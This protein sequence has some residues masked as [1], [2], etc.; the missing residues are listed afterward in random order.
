MSHYDTLKTRLN[1]L[2]R[3]NLIVTLIPTI[4]LIIIGTKWA[5]GSY[6]FFLIYLLGLIALLTLPF[7][8]QF[9]IKHI[10]PKYR[11]LLDE[12]H[13][14]QSQVS[15]L[16]R[17]VDEIYDKYRLRNKGE[18]FKRA[19]DLGGKHIKDCEER[20][21]VGMNREKKEIFV[22]CFIKAGKVVRV[23]ASIGSVFRCSASDDPRRW[24]EHIERLDCDEIRQYHNH[25]I[26]NNRTFPS[27]VDHKTSL[28]LRQILGHHSN[29][30]RSFIIY[31]NEIR[32][33]RVMEY[34]EKGKH[35]LMDEF[36]IAAQQKNPADG[37][38][39]PL[40]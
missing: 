9:V 19:Y 32:E 16:R 36:D 14:I 37:L 10:F 17:S 6:P 5:W 27:P 24:K 15:S 31:W 21:A 1:K 18:H 3:T 34:D 28:S 23:T 20:L 38:Q 22:T 40:I 2:Q 11:A 26:S 13:K 12:L 35:W 8:V 4:F 30:F 7:G 25:P 29:K 33:W 39:P